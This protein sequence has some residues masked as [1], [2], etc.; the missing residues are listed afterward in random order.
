MQVKNVLLYSIQKLN[1]S[2]YSHMLDDLEALITKKD[3]KSCTSR[4]HQK[5]NEHEH[6]HHLK[7]T[8]RFILIC[9]EKTNKIK[10][11]RFV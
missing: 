9:N 4:M 7:S 1:T 10:I 8:A 2:M 11:R 5:P 6:Q 3:L